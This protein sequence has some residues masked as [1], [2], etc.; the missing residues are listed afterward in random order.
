LI[1]DKL[2]KTVLYAHEKELKGSSNEKRTKGQKAKLLGELIA[3][4]AIKK[5]I[6]EIV[7]DRNGYRYHGRVKALADGARSGGL[8]F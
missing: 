8:K 4:K 3:K 1:D 6:T 2:N 7:F 5:D